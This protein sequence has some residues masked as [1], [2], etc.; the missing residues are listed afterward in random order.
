MIKIRCVFFTLSA[1]FFLVLP[2]KGVI[3][4]LSIGF[5]TLNQGAVAWIKLLNKTFKFC[6]IINVYIIQFYN[7][8][9]FGN[10]C[11]LE[12]SSKNLIYFHAIAQAKFSFFIDG[13]F[14]QF[15][16]I[17]YNNCLLYTSPSPR[18]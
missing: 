6:N 14:T 17:G 12:S 10:S 4:C 15:C 9:S 2:F 5:K 3:V 18:D 13:Q 7:N 16:T 8:E 1:Y 11:L